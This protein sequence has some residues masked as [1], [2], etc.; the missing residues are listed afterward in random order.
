MNVSKEADR[1]FMAELKRTDR[2]RYDR[3]THILEKEGARLRRLA[4]QPA[5]VTEI[6]VRK[7][8]HCGLILSPG[9]R[10]DA[11]YCDRTCQRNA[12]FAKTDGRQSQVA[13]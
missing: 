12:R 8:K 5:T 6:T 13:A 7:C 11:S 10:E 4:Q 2:Q 1:A 3:L 9:Q